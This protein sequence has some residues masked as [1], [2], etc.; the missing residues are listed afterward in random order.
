MVD[1]E[2]LVSEED[3]F[4]DSLRRSLISSLT[5]QQATNTALFGN[6]LGLDGCSPNYH[7]IFGGVNSYDQAMTQIG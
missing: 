4:N 2:M 3:T 7:N 6:R 5:P 1:Q